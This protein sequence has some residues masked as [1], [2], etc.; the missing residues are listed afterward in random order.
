MEGD[1]G[2]SDSLFSTLS[3]TPSHLSC[4][5]ISSFSSHSTPSPRLHLSNRISDVKHVISTPRRNVAWISLQNRL[6]GAEEASCARNIG[7]S[8]SREESFAWD[9]FSPLQ[10]VLA[11]AI[12]AAATANGEKSRQICQLQESVNVR[13]GIISVSLRR[14]YNNNP[15]APP[16]FQGLTFFI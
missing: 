15:T 6:I 7:G 5:S 12:V 9:L 4:I 13:V 14:F 2:S 8:L 16:S 10:R 11:V 3:R 1:D